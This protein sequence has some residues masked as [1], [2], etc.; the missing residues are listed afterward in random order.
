MWTEMLIDL[1][2][3]L[4]WRPD[5]YGLGWVVMEIDVGL[6]QG[7]YSKAGNQLFGRLYYSQFCVLLGIFWQMEK[8]GFLCFH[9]S[10]LMLSII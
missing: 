2:C 8:A 1:N 7:A 4:Y 9:P 5:Q 3:W 10:A 6:P